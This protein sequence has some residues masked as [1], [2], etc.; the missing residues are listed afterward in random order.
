MGTG[1]TTLFLIRHGQTVGNTQKIY[2]GQ[3]DTPLTPAGREQARLVGTRINQIKPDVVYS[4]DLGRSVE[5]AEIACCELDKEIQLHKGLRERHF[6]IFQGI[7]FKEAERQYPEIFSNYRGQDPDFRIP[8][9]E[10]HRELID[11]ITKTLK[12]VAYGNAGKTIALFT[13]G[14]VVGYFFAH[15]LGFTM[16]SGIH[17]FAINN[18]SFS[19]FLY[20]DGEFSLQSF[21][22]THHM[23]YT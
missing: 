23:D 5:T 22:D 15:H 14:G 7:G 2:Q 6:G 17:A 8:K 19:K 13:H 3:M 16:E 21:G 11:R 4:S 18:G 9:G 10:T 20:S 12:E 1:Q